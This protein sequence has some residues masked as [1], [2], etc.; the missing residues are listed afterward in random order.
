MYTEPSPNTVPR[1]ARLHT[2]IILLGRHACCNL[3]ERDER[4]VSE[5]MIVRLI[6]NYRCKKRAYSGN[7]RP[8]NAMRNVQN[9][10]RST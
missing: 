3:L 10:T 9:N 6:I 7:A 4:V 8:I 5:I 2:E 1:V